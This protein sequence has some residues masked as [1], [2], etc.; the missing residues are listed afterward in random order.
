MPAPRF[1]R[2]GLIGAT[3][4]V[5][6]LAGFDHSCLG[7]A[8]V[9]PLRQVS[10]EPRAAQ[11]I[12]GMKAEYR[13]PA[14]IPFPAENR[15]TQAKA[16]LGKKLYFD[17]RLSAASSLSCA[18]CHSP[19]FGWGDGMA[20]GSGYGMTRLERR[21]PTVVTIVAAGGTQIRER[22]ALQKEIAMAIEK[23]ELKLHFQPQATIAGEIFGF[24]V[25]V[26]WLHPMRGM[27]SPGL[28]IPLAE[29]T[30]TIEAVD[31]WV[32]RQACREAASWSSPLS[33]AINLSPVD[34]RRGDLPTMIL[35]VLLE[36]GLDPQ[37][38]EVEITEGVLF[39]DFDRAIGILRKIKNLGVR[40]AMDDFGTGYSSLSYLQAFPFDKIKIDQ[41]F[42][43]K[44]GRNASA[45]AIIHAILGLGRALALPVMAEGVETE[46]Q[47]A[48][49]ARE[50][51]REIQGFL[52]GRPEPIDRYRQ[53]T[54]GFADASEMAAAAG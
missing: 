29:E 8:I 51:C 31:E 52:I 37:R 6:G 30:G 42:V 39:E 9:G 12:D 48:F 23:Q 22:R 43:A 35:T 2:S 44:I 28:F 10:V 46:E 53:V 34:F 45:A 26:R 5:A 33:I 15:F 50:G 25:L 19:G 21:S 14:L 49:L 24:E 41:T 3:A 38:L 16:A 11:A 13:R 36:T 20:L 32:L 40:I 4:F 54:T 18:S 17:P 27:V 1:V 47:L 7:A